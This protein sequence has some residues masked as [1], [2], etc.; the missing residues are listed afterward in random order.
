MFWEE[1]RKKEHIITLIGNRIGQTLKPEFDSI[2]PGFGC[3]CQI[4]IGFL[5]SESG[6]ENFMLDRIGLNLPQVHPKLA[7]L[8]IIAR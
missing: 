1:N 3:F 6:S 5:S 2:Q 7:S 8:F 4:E